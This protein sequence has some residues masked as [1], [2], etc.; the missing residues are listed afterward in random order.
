[1]KGKVKKK[2]KK[3]SVTKVRLEAK[4]S[5]LAVCKWVHASAGPPTYSGCIEI[6]LPCEEIYS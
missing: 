2:Y 3:P 6:V 4:V 5:V 1:M